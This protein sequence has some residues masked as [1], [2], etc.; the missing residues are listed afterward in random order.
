MAALLASSAWGIFWQGWGTYNGA[1]FIQTYNMTTESLAPIFTIHGLATVFTSA[2]S[3]RIADRFSKKSLAASGSGGVWDRDR[4]YD[5]P[6]SRFMA[7][8]RFV[9]PRSHSGGPPTYRNKFTAYRIGP[10]ITW[11]SDVYELFNH[12]NWYD[13]RCGYWGCCYRILR[14]VMRRSE[15]S[16]LVLFSLQQ[17]SFMYLLSTQKQ[18]HHHNHNGIEV[19]NTNATEFIYRRTNDFGF[20]QGWF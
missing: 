8:H 19:I 16:M 15:R 9:Y 5:K 14:V 18:H 17:S 6:Y 2:I 10:A 4:T 3:G 7:V 12:P 11:D 13:F 20:I 1:F